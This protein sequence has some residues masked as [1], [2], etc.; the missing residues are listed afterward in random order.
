MGILYHAGNFNTNP[1][2]PLI[3]VYC[4]SDWASDPTTR[5][6]VSG[7]V[8]LFNGSAIDW[9]SKRQSIVAGSS[10]E[11]ELA[12]LATATKQCQYMQQ[13]LSSLALGVPTIPIFTD[14]Q[15]AIE[16]VNG[17]SIGKSKHQSIR[18]FQ[19]RFAVRQKQVVLYHVTTDKQ[20][21]DPLTKP[22][23]STK[24][25][26]SVGRLISPPAT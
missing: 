21:A 18:L 11:A 3:Q 14:S 9:S 17:T 25:L 26:A 23:P 16:L 12:S 19:T 7:L 20:L 6:S 4:D 15:T 10:N 2:K 5:R 13:I 1:G 8:T 24:F 22:L